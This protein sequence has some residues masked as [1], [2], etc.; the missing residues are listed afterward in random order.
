MG[1]YKGKEKRKASQRNLKPVDKGQRLI[2][3]KYGGYYLLQNGDVVEI[4]DYEGIW[5]DEDF[6]YSQEN[7]PPGTRIE[8]GVYYTDQ[9]GDGGV[10]LYTRDDT[11]SDF[12]DSGFLASGIKGLLTNSSPSYDE[13][14]DVFGDFDLDDEERDRKLRAVFAKHG[15]M[16]RRCRA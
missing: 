1:I 3:R 5:E 11:L 10:M 16:N 12:E 14:D 8:G 15:L 13:V 4:H 7:D 6:R 2:E 9:Y